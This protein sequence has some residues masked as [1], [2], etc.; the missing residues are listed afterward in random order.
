MRQHT[1]FKKMRFCLIFEDLLRKYHTGG[2]YIQQQIKMK[3]QTVGRKSS[4]NGYG[5]VSADREVVN[6]YSHSTKIGRFFIYN[7]YSKKTLLFIN[8]LQM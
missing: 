3:A 7:Q 5:K 1:A 4:N 6:V 8:Y 2:D